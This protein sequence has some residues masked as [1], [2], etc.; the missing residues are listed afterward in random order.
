MLGA[1]SEL[2]FLFS[3]ST[4]KYVEN[5]HEQMLSRTQTHGLKLG[6]RSIPTCATS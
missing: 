4:I 1:Y 2:K 5:E 6:F 3:I